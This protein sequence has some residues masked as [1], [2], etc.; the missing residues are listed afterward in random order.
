MPKLDQYTSLKIARSS[1]VAAILVVAIHNTFRISEFGAL[2]PVFAW[3]QLAVNCGITR[4]AVPFF[5]VVSGYFL[6]RDYEPSLGWWGK[7]LKKRACTLGLPYITWIVLGLIQIALLNAVR[8]NP[9]EIA[10]RD[11]SWWLAAVGITGVPVAMITFWFVRILIIA[12]LIAPVLGF[13]LRELGAVVVMLVLISGVFYERA[14]LNWLFIVAGA[15][16]AINGTP[17][18]F[19]TVQENRWSGLFFGIAWA[20]LVV[21]RTYCEAKGVALDGWLE[22]LCVITM[23]ISGIAFMWLLYNKVNADKIMGWIDPFLKSAFFLYAAHPFVALL[24]DALLKPAAYDSY[25]FAYVLAVLY[26][27]YIA[28]IIVPVAVWCLLKRHAPRAVCLCL[29]GDR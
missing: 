4:M 7:K 15:D 6:F 3:A 18:V 24:R 12:V 28:M 27:S 25:S 21:L 16:I 22:N 11:W 1:F 26:G 8:A 23:N 14:I 19:K 10:W 20:A 9:Q 29:F 17:K 2:P 5:F 13:V